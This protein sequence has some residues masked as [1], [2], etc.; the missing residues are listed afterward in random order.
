MLGSALRP[1][2]RAALPITAL[3]VVILVIVAV[4][5]GREDVEQV[6]QSQ[7]VD[8]L[9]VR[10]TFTPGPPP[11]PGATAAATP[12]AGG[13]EG[14]DAVRQRDLAM[15][16]QALEQYRQEHG[17]YP[18]TGGSIQTLCVFSDNDA[19]CELE[20]FLSPLPQDPS[21]NPNTNGYF[22]SATAGQYTLY[23]TREA[24]EIPE[25]VERPDHLGNIDSIYCV[26]EP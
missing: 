25:C 14:R 22:Y 17:E 24:D 7:P 20:E 4:E 26:R 1:D 5:C 23:A 8:L 13:G 12:V 9:S 16:Q 6:V 11:T 3:A 15:I 19:G 18:P 10:P 2:L 21:G